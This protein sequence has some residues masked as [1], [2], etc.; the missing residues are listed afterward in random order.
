MPCVTRSTPSSWTERELVPDAMN[1]ETRLVW[2]G[3]SV[4]VAVVW[5]VGLTVGRRSPAARPPGSTAQSATPVEPAAP[6]AV[7]TM[8]TRPAKLPA[9]PQTAPPSAAPAVEG[10]DKSPSEVLPPAFEHETVDSNWAKDAEVT[11]RTAFAEARVPDGALLSVECRRRI[12]RAEMWFDPRAH[13]AFGRAYGTLREHF[14]AE[15]GFDNISNGIRGEP[16]RL[17]AYFPRKGYA[18]KD[19]ATDSP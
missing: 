4:A 6:A 2:L 9:T 18:L 8:A 16:E 10:R 3:T 15:I 13:V 11:I 12:C 17:A 5:A 1:R 7:P 19:F 14:G